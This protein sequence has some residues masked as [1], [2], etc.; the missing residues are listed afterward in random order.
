[1]SFRSDL[2]TVLIPFKRKKNCPLS[3]EEK[4][5]N[6]DLSKQRITVEHIFRK[7]KIFFEKNIETEGKGML[8]GSI[9]LPPAAILQSDYPDR[10][11]ARGLVY[12]ADYFAVGVQERFPGPQAP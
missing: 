10:A 3:E 6:G 8:S 1:M 4:K 2:K 9:L 12:R 5:A 11:Y 7:L